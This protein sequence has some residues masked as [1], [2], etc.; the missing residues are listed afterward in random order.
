[1]IFSS[2]DQNIVPYCIFNT[3]PKS[4]NT[5][6]PYSLPRKTLLALIAF[7]G[8]L[9]SNTNLTMTMTEYISHIASHIHTLN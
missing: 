3:K 5:K 2:E 6:F 4:S 7:I 1:M 9:A 8:L